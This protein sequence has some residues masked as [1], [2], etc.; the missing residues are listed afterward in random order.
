MHGTTSLPVE[1]PCL[2]RERL[3]AKS[4][5]ATS[6]YSRVVMV[7]SLKSDET[8]KDEYTRIRDYRATAR[9]LAEAARAALDEHL[10]AHGCGIGWRRVR[11]DCGS[12][13][14]MS[15]GG[16]PAGIDDLWC[17]LIREIG[18]VRECFNQQSSGKVLV[19]LE[20]E[21][22]L[23]CE[24]T[25]VNVKYRDDLPELLADMELFVN[26][27]YT[28]VIARSKAQPR[29]EWSFQIQADAGGSTFLSLNG[30]PMQVDEM[31]HFLLV[32]ILSSE[33]P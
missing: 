9:G 8:L 17:V 13:E 33:T 20:K 23:R 24:V 30:R 27:D 1:T 25:V 14:V 28:A 3:L 18:K 19:E 31:S 22:P 4:Q 32:E 2:E 10:L 5:A 12:P 21:H 15:N 29:Q 7:L 26:R 11:R 16:K 6:D